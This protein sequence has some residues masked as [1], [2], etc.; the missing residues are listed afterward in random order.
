MLAETATDW[1]THRADPRPLLALTQAIYGQT[2][3][4]WW[5]TASGRNFDFGEELSSVAEENAPVSGLSQEIDPSED[6]AN[7][8]LK[9]DKR[10][11]IELDYGMQ[12]G[13]TE[14]TT[15]VCHSYYQERP[16]IVLLN[17]D[18]LGAARREV[19]TTSFPGV[20][21]ALKDK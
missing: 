20:K 1:C 3:E 13:M 6:I 5:L 8:D 9:G 18:E 15:C 17:R 4:A 16:Q 19:D 21:T 7:P 14:N 10:R 12:N 11:A 2:P